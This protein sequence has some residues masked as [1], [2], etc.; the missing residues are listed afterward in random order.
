M[1]YASIWL[2]QELDCSDYSLL[3]P[4]VGFVIAM[5]QLVPN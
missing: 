1:K 2:V 5:E 3:E 4:L